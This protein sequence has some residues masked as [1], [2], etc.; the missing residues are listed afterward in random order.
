M[1]SCIKIATDFVTLDDFA[2]TEIVAQE[3]RSEGYND[4]I[5]LPIMVIQAWD[6]LDRLI[7][8]HGLSSVTP[9]PRTKKQKSRVATTQIP[10]QS[11][12]TLNVSE[13]KYFCP[14][15]ACTGRKRDRSHNALFNHM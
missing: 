9:M 2:A 6:S 10:C 3:L 14:D 12:S 11:S 1:A 8:L 5:R 4:V 15:P 7:R 13:D